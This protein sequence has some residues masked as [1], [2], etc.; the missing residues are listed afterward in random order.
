MDPELIGTERLASSVVP[1]AATA[2]VELGDELLAGP[3][4]LVL[5]HPSAHASLDQL[6]ELSPA[7]WDLHRTST[8][9][10]IDQARWNLRRRMV[11]TIAGLDL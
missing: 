6:R 4:V 10:R 5:D 1:T 11:R 7:T 3:T 9:S 2:L 8:S